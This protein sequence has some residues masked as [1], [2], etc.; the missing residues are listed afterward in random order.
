MSEIS[1]LHHV[2]HVV[3]DLR[4]ARD[5]YRRLG[6]ACAVPDYPVLARR[7]GGP[8]T[9]FGAANTHA[10]FAR[11][12]VEI[13]TV[14]DETTSLPPEAHA[15][16]L[17]VPA[18]ALPSVVATIE[19]TVAKISTALARFEGMHILVF[20][21]DDAD[22]TAARFDRVGIHYSGVSVTQRP[23]D[24]TPI[25]GIEIEDLDAPEGRL[26]VA[27]RSPR[28]ASASLDHANGALD[29]VEATLCVADTSI[30][31]VAARYEL[32]LGA[33]AHQNG[34]TWVFD[35]Q[36]S[37][38]RVVPSS[39][40]AETPPALPGFVGYAVTMADLAATRELLATGDVEFQSPSAEEIVVPARA[41]LGAS[42]TLRQAKA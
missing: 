13:L 24:T 27:E 9:P 21:T 28:P 41:A 7:V 3:R 8:A 32:Y 20:E 16:P 10:Y 35:L 39:H 5:L 37:A 4:A 40:E 23:G 17:E 15:I 31:A 38:L 29:L 1:Y 34:A 22:A 12:F 11:N 19:R 36:G 2:G 30:D 26:A 25:R 6:F 14:V 42:V 18:E 33:S